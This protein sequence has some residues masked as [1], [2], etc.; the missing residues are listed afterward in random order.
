MYSVAST[1]F[2]GGSLVGALSVVILTKRI[3]Y[4]SIMLIGPILQVLG[5][6]IYGLSV[7]GWMAALG[8][9][10]IGF[11]HG[12]TLS[13]ALSYYSVSTIEYNKLAASL[14]KPEKPGIRKTLMIA[15]ISVA[16]L[17]YSIGIGT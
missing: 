10:F 5:Y 15:H 6:C 9:G 3:S 14:N 2:N 1:L 4:K 17:G 11:S 12:A 13:V 8:R 7:A 16:G